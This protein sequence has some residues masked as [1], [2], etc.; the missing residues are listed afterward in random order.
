MKKL[1][2]LLFLIITLNIFGQEIKG[3][4][5]RTNV[6]Q[7]TDSVGYKI[8][9]TDI[10]RQTFV[11]LSQDR[12]RVN[13]DRFILNYELYDKQVDSSD[14]NNWVVHFLSESYKR[15]SAVAVRECEGY[16]KVAV[17]PM[18]GGQKFKEYIIKPMKPKVK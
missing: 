3:H 9:K 7:F 10:H 6:C 11:R 2:T 8:I 17:F 12:F 15:L 16:I 13:G 5:V 14:Q 1:F 4:L 18:D